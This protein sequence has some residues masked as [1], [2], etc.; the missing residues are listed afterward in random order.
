MPP[1][2]N[3]L[4]YGDADFIFQQDF[5]LAHTAKGTKSCFNDHGVA[6]LDWPAKIKNECNRTL[7][8]LFQY[9]CSHQWVGWTLKVLSFYLVKHVCVEIANYK[10]WHSVVLYHIH[11]LIIFA[12]VLTP[13]PTEQFCLH[14]SNTFGGHCLSTYA[15]N[16][17]PPLT[18]YS[19]S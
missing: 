8:Q 17:K 4:Y 10:M 5:T 12:N 9:L 19:E 18:V 2:A 11:L 13:Q 14:C 3:K 6:V 1:S 7:M 16:P 15:T